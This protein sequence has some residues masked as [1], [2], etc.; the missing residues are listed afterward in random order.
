MAE[1]NLN[2]VTPS[3]TIF[4][5]EIKS[6]TVPGTVGGFQIL[7]NHAPIIS[8]LEIGVIKIEMLNGNIEFYA[9]GGGTIEVKDNNIELLA[10]SI[11]KSDEIDI[12]RAKA[13]KARAEK[14]LAEKT[15]DKTIDVM[16]AE[17]ALAR[18]A[19][20]LAIYEKYLQGTSAKP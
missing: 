16:R 8:T 5:G 11:E 10:D 4:S 1:L 13:A 14:R 7:K 20:R 9:T 2:I 18:A 6:I 15:N 12:E 3:K 17:E 19:N